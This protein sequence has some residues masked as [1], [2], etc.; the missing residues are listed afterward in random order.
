M[1]RDRTR[2]K[3]G[4][5]VGSISAQSDGV[6]NRVWTATGDDLH[7]SLDEAERDLRKLQREGT[8]VHVD[9][10]GAADHFLV[11]DVEREASGLRVLLREG[12]GDPEGP[13]PEA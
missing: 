13:D 11:L 6:G 5:H 10:A 2:A 1:E 8:P 9:V 4:E 12:G 3:I 7:G